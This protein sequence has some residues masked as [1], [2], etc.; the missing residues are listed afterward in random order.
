LVH[1]C[2]FSTNCSG[3]GRRDTLFARKF[4]RRTS[5]RTTFCSAPAA[6]FLRPSVTRALRISSA[7]NPSRGDQRPPRLGFLALKR[8]GL[9]VVLPHRSKRRG[10]RAERHARVAPASKAAGAGAARG[11]RVYVGRT[12]G[13]AYAARARVRN[14]RNALCSDSCAGRTTHAPP[15]RGLSARRVSLFSS[16]TSSMLNVSYTRRRVCASAARRRPH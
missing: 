12:Q 7:R 4:V 9:V 10:G 13:N 6:I 1:Y 8:C 15:S 2:T 14:K 11:A 3:G 16:S 5:T